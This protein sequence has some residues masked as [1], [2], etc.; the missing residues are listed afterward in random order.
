MPQHITLPPKSEL[1]QMYITEK[2]TSKEIGALY[3]CSYTTVINRL[4]ECSIPVRK[5]APR[6]IYSIPSK[7]ELERLYITE[8]KSSAQIASIYNCSPGTVLGWL[9]GHEIRVRNKGARNTG[10][11]VSKGSTTCGII[12]AHDAMLKDDPE[13]LDLR[14]MLSIEC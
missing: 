4:H 11:Y 14:K 2:M 5:S 8:Y 3:E 13:K 10:N 12:R 7:E 1:E 6:V 9:H